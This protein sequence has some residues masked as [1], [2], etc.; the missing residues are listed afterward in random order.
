MHARGGNTVNLDIVYHY[1]A[2][3][4]AVFIKEFHQVSHLREGGTSRFPW[5]HLDSDNC[6]WFCWEARNFTC[7]CACTCTRANEAC[8]RSTGIIPL[9]R[10]HCCASMLTEVCTQR[11]VPVP[12][13]CGT[14]F[15]CPP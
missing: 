11:L 12:R 7:T 3:R 5:T 14:A 6:C 8:L 9:L 13:L 10:T 2:T 15:V 1:I 4:V